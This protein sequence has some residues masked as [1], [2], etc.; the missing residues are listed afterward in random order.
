MSRDQ[1]RRLK[2]REMEA[3]TRQ[4]EAQTRQN[5]AQTQEKVS[6]T[7]YIT[8]SLRYSIRILPH[9]FHTDLSEQPSTI[10]ISSVLY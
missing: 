5:E 7:V 4:H 3:R 6:V 10:F 2:L 9:V 8:E 1:V